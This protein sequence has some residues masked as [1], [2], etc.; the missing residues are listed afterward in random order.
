MRTQTGR[1]DSIKPEL[2]SF[3]CTDLD[4]VEAWVPDHPEVRYWLTMAI[5]L[6]GSDA[7]DL[8]QV[9][10]ATLDG[11]KSERGRS[12]RTRGRG[13]PQPIVLRSYSWAAVLHAVDERLE[14]CRGR[15]WLEIQEN[16]RTQFWWEYEGMR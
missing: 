11:L 7:A 9:C 3:D 10:V 5:G 16:L 8:F 6:P 4:P 14:S 2:K 13:H 12:E 1:G 15:D